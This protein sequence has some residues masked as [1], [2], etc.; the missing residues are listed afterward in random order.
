MPPVTLHVFQPT[1]PHCLSLLLM[2]FPQI[3]ATALCCGCTSRLSLTVIISRPSAHP[4]FMGGVRTL[5]TISLFTPKQAFIQVTPGHGNR[6]SH[7]HLLLIPVQPPLRRLVLLGGCLSPAAA[8]R[9]GGVGPG[10]GFCRSGRRGARDISEGLALVPGCREGHVT[11][12]ASLRTSSGNVRGE[13]LSWE[14]TPL[15]GKH[16]EETRAEKW[17]RGENTKEEVRTP[18]KP[19]GPAVPEAWLLREMH[20]Q[21]SFFA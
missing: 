13:T 5:L 11:T 3:L 16:Q 9:V 7:R 18:N 15:A 2:S 4:S 12:S 6:H 8:C 14:R 10:P 20:Q 1:L 21:L 19:L 17:G